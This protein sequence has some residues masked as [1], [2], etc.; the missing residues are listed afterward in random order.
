VP[1]IGAGVHAQL[2]AAPGGAALALLLLLFLVL[3][4]EDPVVPLRLPGLGVVAVVLPLP[5]AFP[6]LF[7]LGMK[8]SQPGETRDAGEKAANRGATC[9]PP[10]GKVIE[11]RTVHAV[12]HSS[13]MRLFA[14]LHSDRRSEVGHQ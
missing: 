11:P 8:V 10:A 1:G 2:L 7:R 9:S 6:L 14:L 5:L 4:G 13:A 3:F 12:L